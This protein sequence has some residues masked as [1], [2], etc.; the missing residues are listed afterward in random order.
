MT[1][2]FVNKSTSHFEADPPLCGEDKYT[3]KSFEH[4]R[5]WV[6]DRMH[7]LASIFS[8]DI[9]AYAPVL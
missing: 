5:Q 1:S 4:R 2:S 9:C 6:V 8:I 7:H 3:E